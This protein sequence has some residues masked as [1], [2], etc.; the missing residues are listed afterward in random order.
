M[1]SHLDR[2]C[3]GKLDETFLDILLTGLRRVKYFEF[4]QEDKRFML[5]STLYSFFPNPL[6]LE[7][8]PFL[9]YKHQLSLHIQSG[10]KPLILITSTV[11]DWVDNYNWNFYSTLLCSFNAL[12]ITFAI[13]YIQKKALRDSFLRWVYL[14]YSL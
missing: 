13:E 3:I 5:D 8:S 12:D 7:L 11:M 14:R 6:L 2:Q 9:H 1:V 10:T 4:S